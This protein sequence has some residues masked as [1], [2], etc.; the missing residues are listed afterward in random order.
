[1]IRNC[2]GPG[3]LVLLCGVGEFGG[4]EGS[5][6]HTGVGTDVLQRVK[7]GGQL[8]L[9]CVGGKGPISYTTMHVND[10]T[11]GLSGGSGPRNLGG[12]APWRARQRE[13][14][15]GVWGQ[16]PQRDPGAEPLV[17]GQGVKLP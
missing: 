1:V 15:A 13:P 6:E 17:R 4:S 3:K 14:I 8:S 10:L 5:L 16:S 11:A 12:T 9:A 2:R 7:G